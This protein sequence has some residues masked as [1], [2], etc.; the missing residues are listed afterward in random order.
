MN[1][2]TCQKSRVDNDAKRDRC[3]YGLWRMPGGLVHGNIVGFD[4][5]CDVVQVILA[6]EKICAKERYRECTLNGWKA[7]E[8]KQKRCKS[9]PRKAYRLEGAKSP[10]SYDDVNCRGNRKQ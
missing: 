7:S 9:W 5:M 6:N 4:M 10:T 3:V 1:S 8:C 2:H